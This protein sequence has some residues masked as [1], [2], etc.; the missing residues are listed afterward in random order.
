MICFSSQQEING[1]LSEIFIRGVVG[2]ARGGQYKGGK[3][4]P[5]M[6]NKSLF[7]KQVVYRVVGSSLH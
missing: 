3:A 1:A 7:N 4:S 2:T 6:P 5:G